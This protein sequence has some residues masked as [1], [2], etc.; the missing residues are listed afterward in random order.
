MRR[1]DGVDA[2]RRIR[3]S[4]ATAAHVPIIG[5]T[6][7]VLTHQRDE[8]PAAGMDVVVGKPVSPTAL[9]QEVLRIAR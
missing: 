1:L 4:Q 9:L 2:T 5:L 8:Y 6:A 7:N 3:G